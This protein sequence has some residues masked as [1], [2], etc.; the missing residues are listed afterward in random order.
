MKRKTAVDLHTNLPPDYY[1]RSIKKNP[2][3]WFWHHRRF[4]NVS[5][6]IEP[7]KGKV[8]DIGSADGTF[9][10]VI[11][12]KSQAESVIGIDILAKSVKYAN[13]RFLKDKR[14]KFVTADVQDL[15]FKDDYFAAVFCLEVAE[16]LAEPL[17]VFR[18]INRVLKPGG[19]LIVLVPTDS[20]LFKKIWWVVLHT[21]GKHWQGTHLQSFNQKQSLTK[22]VSKAGFRVEKEKFFLLKMLEAVK[23]KKE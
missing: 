15:P 12:E 23:A 1:E 22:M 4:Q 6:L 19:Y 7:V 8:L 18:E 11:T 16:H 3:Q 2:L 17:K 13:Q 20:W 21:W 9:T 5:Q 14:I 10:K